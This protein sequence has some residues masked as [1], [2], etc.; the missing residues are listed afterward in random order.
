MDDW[1][2]QIVTIQFRV[3]RSFKIAFEQWCEDQGVTMSAALISFIVQRDRIGLPT[4]LKKPWKQ[5]QR[6]ESRNTKISGELPAETQ[7]K[8]YFSSAKSQSKDSEP[9]IHEERTS[10]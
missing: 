3:P 6:T 8:E 7:P 1:H 10:F 4:V 5:A 2:D 9:Q